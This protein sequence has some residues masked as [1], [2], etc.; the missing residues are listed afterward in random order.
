MRLLLGLTGVALIVVVLVDAFETMVLP[1]RVTRPYRPARAYY[2]IAWGL[3]RAIACRMLKGKRRADFLGVFGPLSLIVLFAFWASGLIGGFAMVHA[4]LGTP[5]YRAMEQTP[6]GFFEY[7][8][9]SGVTFFTLGYGDVAPTQP[10]GRLLAVLEAG[11]GFGFFGLVIS[12][13]PGLSQSSSQRE[14]T[15]SLLDARAGSPPTAAE[16]ITRAAR[17]GNLSGSTAFFA[18]WERWAA[19]VLESHLSY[20]VLMYYRSQHDNQSWLAALT[21]VCDSCALV[22]AGVEG[23]PTF[24]AQLTFAMARHALVDLSLIIQAPPIEPSSKRLSSAD[25]ARLKSMLGE[26][27]LVFTDGERVE[28]RLAELRAMYEPFASGLSERLMLA[29]PPI[30]ASTKPVD[31]WQTSAWTRRT[32][33]IGDLPRRDEPEHF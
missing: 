15:I 8:Y 16:G 17:S 13:L 27:G 22:L 7:F 3:W 33:G 28:Q 18:E 2:R 10:L 9:L 21:A 5:V 4:S 29:I 11:L 32:P 26:A 1:R 19:Q 30:V 20:P 25:F 6:A 24:Q 31:N 12:Y 14:L 23:V